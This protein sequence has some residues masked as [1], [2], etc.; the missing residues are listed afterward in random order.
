MRR[1]HFSKTLFLLII[2]A[3]ACTFAA[4]V[5]DAQRRDYLTDDE[6]EIVRDAQQIDLRVAV[7]AHA[8]DRRLAALG[9]TTGEP[10]DKDKKEKKDSGK[11]GAEPK[12]T[13]LELLDD[14]RRIIQK[15]VDDID[16]LAERPDSIVVEEPGKGQKPKKYEDV[17]PKAVRVLASAAKRYEP[18]LKKEIDNSKDDK[19]KG[20]IMQSLDLCNQIIDAETR[21]ASP[22]AKKSGS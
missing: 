19:E 8:V 22:Q 17:F 14:V 15:A 11:W 10:L 12:G 2:G 6:V 1:S 16:N 20:V 4:N 13:R 18:L 9:L 7:L 3:A 5:A 21:L